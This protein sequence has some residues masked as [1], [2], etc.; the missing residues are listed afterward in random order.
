MCKMD[1]QN[2]QG[3]ELTDRARHGCTCVPPR[4]LLCLRCLAGGAE[5]CQCD[6]EEVTA[7]LRLVR[8][9]PDTCLKL[10]TAFDA[11][12][13]RTSLFDKTTPEERKR[14]LDVLCRLGLVPGD[15][16]SARD[17][18]DRVDKEIGD[19]SGICC[20]DSDNAFVGTWAECPA[21]RTDAFAKGR[22]AVITWARTAADMSVVK[23]DSCRSIA[24]ASVLEIRAHHLLCIVCYIRSKDA[25]EPL[26]EDN[27]YEAWL[28]MQRDPQLPVRILEGAGACVVCPPCPGYREDLRMCVM[29]CHLRDR[30][31]DLETMLRLGVKPGD[32]LPA[33]VLIERIYR[34][35]PDT[36]GICLLGSPNRFE[37]RDCK[38]A[39]GYR[40]GLANG[41]L[42]GGDDNS[43]PSVRSCTGVTENG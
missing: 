23:A 17:L 4:Y 31:K 8:H 12:G 20:Y 11:M 29:D 24:E 6:P 27:L 22:G 39:G 3:L 13:G 5:N 7:L 38:D 30:K 25:H 43:E 9:E 19:L 14:D 32:V 1:C 21:A 40:K 28:R 36:E 18:M 2:C 35:I 37:W 33:G 26:V 10:T 15:E 42:R 41:Y 34:Y 16:R